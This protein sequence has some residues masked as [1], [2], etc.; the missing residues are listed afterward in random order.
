[1]SSQYQRG[2]RNQSH[3]SANSIL[4]PNLV[5]YVLSGQAIHKS[6]W[7]IA[8]RAGGIPLQIRDGVDGKLVPPGNPKAIAEAMIDYYTSEKDKCKTG[9]SRGN[10]TDR[11]LGGRWTSEGEG[12]REELFSIGN[13]T[14]WHVST[15]MTLF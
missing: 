2:L 13:A 11:P 10:Y 7:I 14:M 12:P 9:E 15:S 3:R 4:V 6:R 8:T 1:M 5:A